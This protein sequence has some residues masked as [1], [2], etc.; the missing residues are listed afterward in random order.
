MGVLMDALLLCRGG[1]GEEGG[2]EGS[3]G[4]AVPA[5]QGHSGRQGVR[6]GIAVAFKANWVAHYQPGLCQNRLAASLKPHSQ[7]S[8]SHSRCDHPQIEKVVVSDRIVDSPCVLVTGEY[9][10]SANMERIMKAQ[11]Q[12][13]RQCLPGCTGRIRCHCT[14]ACVV[15]L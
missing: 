7:R 15:L 8:G 3:P 1:E 11:V 10:W 4:A 13:R 5:S 6:F 12:S 2:A 14:V 9:G